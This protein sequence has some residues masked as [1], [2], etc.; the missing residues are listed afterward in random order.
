MVFKIK[1]DILRFCNLAMFG[2]LASQLVAYKIVDLKK[3]FK[4]DREQI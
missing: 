4:T 2:H 3:V 1:Y